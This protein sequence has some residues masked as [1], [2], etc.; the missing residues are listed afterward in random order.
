MDLDK[1]IK[2]WVEY[3][4]LIKQ[5]SEKIKLLREDKLKVENNIHETISSYK[6]KPTIRISD[7]ILK[8]NTVNIQQPIS[9]KLIEN[10]LR[11]VIKSESQLNILMN[12]IKETR[13]TKQIDVIKRYYR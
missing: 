2:K 5:F 13:S 7:G 4:S 12:T 6:N 3:D 8:F 1:N 10:S 11:K 9:Y